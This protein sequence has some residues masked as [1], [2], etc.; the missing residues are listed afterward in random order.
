[1]T[2]DPLREYVHERLPEAVRAQNSRPIGPEGPKGKGLNK[3]HRGDRR[4]VQGWSPEQIARRF[5]VDFPNDDSMEIGCREPFRLRPVH[6]SQIRG[7]RF[8]EPGSSRSTSRLKFCATNYHSP[9]YKTL[10]KLRSYLLVQLAVQLRSPIF[11]VSHRY[12]LRYL[13]H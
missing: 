10:A 9:S 3:P 1:M 5:P 2:N 11:Q 8:G 12:P 4:W 7:P 6:L 13:I